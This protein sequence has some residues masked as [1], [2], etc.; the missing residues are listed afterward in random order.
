MKPR[1]YDYHQGFRDG[2]EN[3][4]YVLREAGLLTLELQMEWLQK[5]IKEGIPDTSTNQK[6]NQDG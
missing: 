6:E 2:R 5:L 1:S 3:A 4:L